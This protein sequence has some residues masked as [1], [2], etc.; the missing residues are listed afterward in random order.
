M[1]NCLSAP[2]QSTPDVVQNTYPDEP[3]I[4]PASVEPTSAQEPEPVPEPKPAQEAKPPERKL[5][6]RTNNKAMTLDP[7]PPREESQTQ[8]EASSSSHPAVPEPAPA[9]STEFDELLKPR[10]VHQRIY[11]L[12]LRF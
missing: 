12:F 8:M 10:T 1:N 4:P 3:S 11:L 5:T 2:S 7:S 6:R 9:E